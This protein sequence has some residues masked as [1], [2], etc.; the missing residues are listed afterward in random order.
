MAD[1]LPTV[2]SLEELAELVQGTP[3]LY[4]RWSRGP[5]ADA[6]GTSR[7]ELT[8]VELP[9]PCANPLTVEEWWGDR[10][11]HTWV[12]R[13][14][15]D[16]RHLKDRRGKGIRPWVL[17]G[18]ELGRGPDNEPIVRYERAVAWIADGVVDEAEA[19]LSAKKKD[20]G[21]LDRGVASVASQPRNS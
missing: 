1:D 12:A 13:R 8:D 5:D 16:Y 3:N 4:V 9:G 10:P 21:P 14:L 2:Q 15:Y 19:K 20:W 7:D 17:T 11:L 6:D 18:E